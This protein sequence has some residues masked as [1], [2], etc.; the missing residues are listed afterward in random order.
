MKQGDTLKPL[1]IG[2]T[3]DRENA[4]FYWIPGPGFLGT[5]ELVFIETCPFQAMKK[6][7]EITILPR[8]EIF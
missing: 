5:Y 1:P 4:I 6:T 2:S 3:F 8:R 7:V